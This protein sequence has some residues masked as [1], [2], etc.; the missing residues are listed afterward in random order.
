[1]FVTT[2]T[3]GV[4]SV[5]EW[6]D[7]WA[8]GTGMCVHVT[9][10]TSA[11]AAINLAGPRSRE[12]LQ[13]LTAADVSAQAAPYLAAGHAEGARVP[14]LLLRIGFVGELGYEMHFPAEYGEHLWQALIEAGREFGIRPFGVEAQRILRLE[15]GHIIVSQDTDAL[16]NP[17][18]AGM[19][20]IVKAQ[21]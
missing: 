19:G 13:K 10:V 6:L 2:T 3:S 8:A 11:Y 4:S 1:F 21:K 16:T 12:V 14:A 5:Q 9:N 17:Y 20:W 7:W 18:E 15:K